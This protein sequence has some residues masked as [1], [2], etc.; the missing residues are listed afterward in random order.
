MTL[1][2]PPTNQA[3]AVGPEHSVPP[4]QLPALLCQ[5]SGVVPSAVI[6]K[7]SFD[8]GKRRALNGNV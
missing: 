6:T 8:T 3:E 7:E 2:V 5:I 1:A 4:A